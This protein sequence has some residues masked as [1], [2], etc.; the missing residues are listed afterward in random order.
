[1]T[2]ADC[3]K[4]HTKSSKVFTQY[5]LKKLGTEIYKVCWL[6]KKL[7]PGMTITLK[8]LDGKYNIIERYGDIEADKLDLNRNIVWYSLAK[9]K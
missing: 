2:F 5:K 7:N 1:M 6:D 9:E 3:L 4:D 8:G